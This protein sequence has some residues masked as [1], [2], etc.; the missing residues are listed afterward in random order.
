MSAQAHSYTIDLVWTGNRGDGTSG[1]RVY[2]RAYEI[3]VT[4]KAVLPGS[5]DPHFLGDAS[6]YNPEELLVASLSACHMLSF[7]HL[8]ADTGIRVERYSDAA[9][10]GWS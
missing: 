10:G 3:S 4:G 2:D 7:L 6:R 5:S 8:C 1:Y 9:V